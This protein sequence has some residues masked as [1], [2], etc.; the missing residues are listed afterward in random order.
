MP[1]E[2]QGKISRWHRLRATLPP[3]RRSVRALANR[4]IMRATYVISNS[5]VATLNKSKKIPEETI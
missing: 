1:S 2:K 5:Q 4:N 3:L